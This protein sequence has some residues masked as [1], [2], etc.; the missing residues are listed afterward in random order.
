MEEDDDWATRIRYLLGK[1]VNQ[2]LGKE[3]V[4]LGLPEWTA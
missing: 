2:C 3:T 1:V 4:A